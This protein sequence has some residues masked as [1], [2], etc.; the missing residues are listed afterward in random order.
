MGVPFLF[1]ESLKGLRV[2]LFSPTQGII[3]RLRGLSSKKSRV[4][5]SFNSLL[6]NLC[7]SRY[8]FVWGFII[9]GRKA[10]GGVITNCAG[11]VSLVEF[12]FVV[13]CDSPITVYRGLVVVTVFLGVPL[14][15]LG[16]P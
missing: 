12:A 6:T 3:T 9:V 15:F 1:S 10:R 7:Y 14:F 16:V 8:S 13:H 11:I 5:D 2:I 4:K